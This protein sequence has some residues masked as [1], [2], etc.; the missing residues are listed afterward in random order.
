MTSG[1]MILHHF[2]VFTPG[3]KTYL[4]TAIIDLNKDYK[5][6][7]DEYM[8]GALFCNINWSLGLAIYHLET[9]AAKYASLKE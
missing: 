1:T 9:L 8:D 5:E 4:N 6:C 3:A 2:L 7:E